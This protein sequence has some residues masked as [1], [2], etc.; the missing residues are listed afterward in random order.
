LA[1]TRELTIQIYKEF[2]ILSENHIT[3]APRVTFLRKSHIPKHESGLKKLIESTEILIASP[4]KMANLCEL[5]PTIN[6]IETI[7]VDE[8]DKMFEMG[9]LEQVD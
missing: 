7:V 4:L 1:P 6:T 3:V 5:F 9:F 2:L 8:A